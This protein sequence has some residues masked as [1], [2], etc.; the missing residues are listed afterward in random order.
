MGLVLK[1]LYTLY[2]KTLA[3]IKNGPPGILAGP[4]YFMS[5]NGFWLT[6]GYFSAFLENTAIEDTLRIPSELVY[7]IEFILNGKFLKS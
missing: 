1:F 2:F 6:M 4:S 5:Q 3:T 7:N